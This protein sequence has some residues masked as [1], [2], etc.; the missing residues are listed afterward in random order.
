[1]LP[2]EKWDIAKNFCRRFGGPTGWGVRSNTGGS[3]ETQEAK[4]I[5][6]HVKNVD[7]YVMRLDSLSFMNAVLI[8]NSE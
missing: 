5:E 8:T 7:F 6:R 2:I 4:V 1:M 3:E